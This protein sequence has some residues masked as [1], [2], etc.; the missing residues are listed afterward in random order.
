MKTVM[1]IHF[2]A[3]IYTEENWDSKGL[4]FKYRALLVPVY[5][6]AI[7]ICFAGSFDQKRETNHLDELVP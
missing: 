7:K 6:K 5:F 2:T 1:A 4:N 3:T